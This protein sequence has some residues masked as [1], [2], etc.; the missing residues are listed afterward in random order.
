MCTVS[1]ICKSETYLGEDGHGEQV[2]V[3]LASPTHVDVDV[4]ARVVAA[5]HRQGLVCPHLDRR[6]C[7]YHLLSVV[8][9]SV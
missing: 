9:K 5:E 2:Q 7:A 1:E 8:L 6:L 4:L 3:G